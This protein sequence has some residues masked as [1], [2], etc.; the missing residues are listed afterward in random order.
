M[1]FSALPPSPA[2]P[3]N[4]VVE[5]DGWWPDVDLNAMRDALR[6]TTTVT[7]PRLVGALEGGVISVTGELEAWRAAHEGEGAT[8]LA[9][10]APTRRIAGQ[11]RL[12]LLY[13]RAVRFAAAAEL[14]ELHRDLT[15]TQDGQARAD[16][17]E[18]TAQEYLRLST[19]AIR[20]ILAVPRTA[21]E[22]I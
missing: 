3:P 22:L 14:A 15:A 19:L 20:D 17:E 18:T 13:T 6:L 9:D 8:S 21:V 12:T 1:S 4:S 16:T 5:G 7:H 11:H 10:V 2:S